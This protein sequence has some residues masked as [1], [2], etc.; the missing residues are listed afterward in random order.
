MNAFSSR[1]RKDPQRIAKEDPPLITANAWSHTHFLDGIA[2]FPDVH[3]ALPGAQ[4]LLQGTFNMIDT[5]IH[6]KGKVLLQQDISHIATGW[7]SM[8]LKPLSPF[9]RHKGAG[10]VVSIAVTGTS[11]YPKLGLDVLHGK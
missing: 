11:R 9:F 7:K 8:L 2:Y 10:T 6:L 4:A 1:V 5:R 3:V